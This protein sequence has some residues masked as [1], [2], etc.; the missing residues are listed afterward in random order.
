MKTLKFYS[1]VL[2]SAFALLALMSCVDDYHEDPNRPMDITPS[3]L[4]PNIEASTF[5]VINTDIAVANRYIAYIDEAQDAQYYD[6]ERGDFFDQYDA[7]K[8]VEKMNEAAEENDQEIYKI[9]GSFLKTYHFLNMSQ[10]YGDIPYSEAVSKE[11]D[12]EIQSPAYDKQEDIFL[13]ALDKLEQAN[14]KLAE[15][16]ETLDGDIIYEGD[17]TQWR[18]LINSYRLRVLMTLSKKANNG[19]FTIKQKFA[20][21]VE[22]PGDNPIMES[23][24]DNGALHYQDQS[25]TRYP[26]Y[27]VNPFQ[28]AY[29]MEESFVDR[30]KE[31]EDPRLFKIAEEKSNTDNVD[32]EDPFSYYEGLY[33][34]DNTGDNSSKSGNGNASRLDPRYWEDP[35]NDP[36]LLMSYPEQQFILAEAVVRDWIDGD[37]NDYYMEGIQ[38]SM[39]FFDVDP[40]EASAYKDQAPIELESGEKAKAIEQIMN[41]KQVAL[42]INTGWQI[43]FENRRT[44]YPELNNDGSG[45]RN[46]GKI[47]KRWRYPKNESNE[48]S[49]N[50][51]EALDRQ[52]DGDDDRFAKM[53]LLKD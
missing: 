45:A 30:L 42:F 12:E 39:N 29:F 33:G 44:G 17:L 7:I 13:D 14:Q 21:I 24:D 36:S 3:A 52:F 46:G 20:D 51:Q 28:T 9:I 41:E 2:G 26:F 4:L 6:W 22:N 18:K 5:D 34:S 32:E 53:W 38:A 35:V 8:Q 49:E 47:P 15:T 37:A 10:H 19:E 11:D 50:L 16:D 48:N 27:K 43:F 1:S 40:S 31:K 25:D 23:N